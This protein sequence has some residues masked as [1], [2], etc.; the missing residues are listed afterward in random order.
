MIAATLLLA[1]LAY[2]IGS[3]PF[4][5]MLSQAFAGIDLRNFGSGNIGAT[6]VL[7]TG[8]R[9]LALATV[10]LD[11]A[12][13]A[14]PLLILDQLRRAGLPTETWWPGL[15]AL[16]VCLGH[17]YSP[18]LGFQGGKAVACF[19]GVWLTLL[20]ISG[21]TLGLIWL[22]VACIWRHSSLAALSAS[23]AAP[24]L[25]WDQPVLL[26]FMVALSALIWRRHGQNLGRLLAGTEPKI[27]QSPWS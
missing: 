7:R 15:L 16:M 17:C 12:K 19:F 14:L 24:I 9:G 3:I 6:N 21:L 18:W 25:V 11:G 22:L 1:I 2:L 23:F 4:G 13:A 5:L 26:G 27:G 10:L 20:F 8:N